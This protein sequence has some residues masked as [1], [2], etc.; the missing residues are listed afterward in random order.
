[1]AF[2]SKWFD[3]RKELE[4]AEELGIGASGSSVSSSDKGNGLRTG[5]KERKDTIRGMPYRQ[6][7]EL[8]VQGTDKTDKIPA[9]AL[10]LDGRVV[11]RVIWETPAA[12]VFQDEGGRFWR[13]LYKCNQAWSVIV[14]G[15][16]TANG[17]TGSAD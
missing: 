5:I 3:W 11:S 12:V 7:S 17:E 8:Y 1:M 14:G 10:C 6:N 16:R 2:E 9:G 4:P 13:Y 15:G